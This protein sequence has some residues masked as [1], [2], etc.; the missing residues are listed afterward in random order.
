MS[1]AGS[2]EHGEVHLW[3]MNPGDTAW[4]AFAAVLSDDEHEKAMRY[5][6]LLLQQTTRRCRSA[7][8]LVLG[9]YANQPAVSLHFSYGQ[10]GKPELLHRRLRF[11][12]SHSGDHALMAISQHSV[13][14]DLEFM[15]RQ[16][17]AE[18]SGLI[19]L[20][21]HPEEKANL[22]LLPETEKAAMFYRLWTQKEAYCKMLGVGLQQSLDRLRFRATAVPSVFQVCDEE[23]EQLSA[24]FV[25]NLCL[26]DGY[27]AS[28]CLPLADARIGWFDAGALLA[29]P[30]ACTEA[31]S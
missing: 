22:A 24:S 21:C 17:N 14:V 15:G 9:L 28:L 19:D 29:S 6:T 20:V 26:L 8:R 10:F 27:A 3:Q 7:L 23:S 1:L 16:A 4:D 18:L 30:P 31:A 11:N 25:H 5:R 13:G 2:L 12:L